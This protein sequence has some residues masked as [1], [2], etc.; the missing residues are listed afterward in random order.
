MA[1]TAVDITL[2][3]I[4]CSDEGDGPGSAE[5]YLWTVFFKVDGD[6]VSFESGALQGNCDRRRNPGQ[7][8]GPG[9]AGERRRRR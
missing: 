9:L 6:T 4:H 7:P 5:P 3:N 8:R 1:T 2:R